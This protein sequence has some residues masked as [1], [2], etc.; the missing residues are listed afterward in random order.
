ML[1]LAGQQHTVQVNLCLLASC[2]LSKE[3]EDS[4]RAKF[5]SQLSL[6]MATNL[7]RLG[8]VRTERYWHMLAYQHHYCQIWCY[9]HCL[10]TMFTDIDKQRLT[11]LWF[12][13]HFTQNRSFRRH[14]PKPICWLVMEKKLNLTQK[15]HAFTNQ[16]K[17]TTTHT[18]TRLT[19][20][21]PVLPR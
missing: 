16:K 21:C 7:F 18:H 13:S 5:Y 4:V 15:K 10:C 14:F 19:A 12:S 8:D 17:C 6:L 9:L 3:L 1:L 11:E 2:D 20:L